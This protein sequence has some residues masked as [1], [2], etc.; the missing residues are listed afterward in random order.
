[1]NDSLSNIFSAPKI[2]ML[3][4][5]IS[6]FAAVFSTQPAPVEEAPLC[7]GCMV[8]F[9]V[10]LQFGDGLID[11]LKELCMFFPANISDACME[12]ATKEL[13]LI[14][15]WLNYDF[16]SK[17]LCTIIGACHFPIDPSE[18]RLCH[19]CEVGFKL[20]EDV[21]SENP[22]QEAIEFLLEY[23]CYAVPEGNQRDMCYKLIESYFDK[24]V[25]MLIQKYPPGVIC[26]AIG[27]C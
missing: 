18:T 27:V 14:V 17:F 1:M 9:D 5:L 20:L 23:I 11:A 8:G 3:G 15:Q 21:V 12:L 10:L 16:S 25:D 26:H 22:S 19:L 6:L 2:L 13:N 7:V 4:L 24:L